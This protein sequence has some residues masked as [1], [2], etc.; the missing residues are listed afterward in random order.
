MPEDRKTALLKKVRAL[1][2]KADSTNFPEEAETFRA[3]ADEMMAQYTLAAWEVEAGQEESRPKPISRDFDT[4]WYWGSH[5]G[6]KW[7]LFYSVAYH[8]R[9][10]V[11]YWKGSRVTPIVGLPADLDYLDML[12]TQLLLEMAK[13]IE[14]KPDP[15]KTPEENAYALRAAGVRWPRTTQLMYEIGQVKIPRGHQED[16]WGNL[17]DEATPFSRL[18]ERTRQTMKNKLAQQVRNHRRAEGLEDY[19][20]IHPAVYQRSFVQGFVS[21]IGSRLRALRREE[22]REES[23]TDNSLALAVRDIRE[24]VA[25]VVE[26]IHGKPPTST[27]SSSLARE[28]KTDGRAYVA[29]SVSAR[30]VSLS[31]HPSKRVSREKKKELPR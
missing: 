31:N 9:C 5:G 21:E 29:G 26:E 6:A 10:K 24:V 18:P 27:G 13:R 22:G 4:S 15:K 2:A 12:F 19:T 28:L 8:C 7:Q 14:P 1:I 3:K 20:E 17:I 25:E 11:V 23:G 16:Y 30:E